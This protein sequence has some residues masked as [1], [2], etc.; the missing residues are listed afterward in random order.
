MKQL[1]GIVIVVLL[2]LGVWAVFTTLTGNNQ[3]NYQEVA[4]RWIE[5]ESPTYLYDGSELEH[6]G[7]TEREVGVYE[8]T[9]TF[10]SNQAGY[11]D[12]SEEMSAQVIT[13]HEIIVTVDNGEVV[14]AVTDG[15]YNELAGELI[16][17]DGGGGGDEVVSLYFYDEKADTDA[18]G[19]ILCSSEAVLATE[20][21]VAEYSIENH[22]EALLNGPTAEEEAAGFSSEFPLEGVSLEG[23]SGPDS[24]GVLTVT[25]SDS[26]N[27]L[28]G[29]SCRVGILSS[30]LTKTGLSIPGVESVVILPEEILQP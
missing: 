18:T 5:E 6:V 23:V 29:G 17:R 7:V 21:V 25:L 15:I 10:T 16:V 22:F 4:E 3:E 11:G 20:R 30:Q 19:N 1:A 14:S 8:H 24:E 12:R 9:F 2:I 27:A 26:A 28:S 13:P